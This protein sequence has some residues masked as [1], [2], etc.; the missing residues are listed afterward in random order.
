[1]LPRP[2]APARRLPYTTADMSERLAKRK[3]EQFKADAL[4]KLANYSPLDNKSGLEKIGS[5]I[6]GA[7]KWLQDN[8]PESNPISTPIN[9]GGDAGV[10]MGG[11]GTG[12]SLVTEPARLAVRRAVGDITAIPRVG[13]PSPSYTAD[14][15]REQGV[16]RGVLGAAIDYSQFIPVVAKGAG[17]TGD[18]VNAYKLAMM[19]R[20]ANPFPALRGASNVID[21]VEGSRLPAR[22]VKAPATRLAKAQAARDTP[23][24][25]QQTGYRTEHTKWWDATKH[26]N[27]EVDELGNSFPSIDNYPNHEGIWVTHKF[28]DALKYGDD[29][30][31]VDL[32]NATPIH[33]DG[34]GGYFYIRP[35]TSPA[36]PATPATRLG[37]ALAQRTLDA[38]AAQG[39]VRDAGVLRMPGSYPAGERYVFDYNQSDPAYV[40]DKQSTNAISR[41]YD[42]VGPGEKLIDTKGTE[43]GVPGRSYTSNKMIALQS[44]QGNAT[45]GYDIETRVI[46]GT[47]Q[48]R[49]VLQ[50]IS[51]AKGSV[52]Q[53]KQLLDFLYG[54]YKNAVIDWG[55]ISTELPN[56]LFYEYNNR[57]PVRTVGESVGNPL[58]N[59]N[60]PKTNINVLL[61]TPQRGTIPYTELYDAIG[62]LDNNRIYP[63]SEFKQLIQKFGF[64]GREREVLDAFARREGIV[65]PSRL[66][67]WQKFVNEMQRQIDMGDYFNQ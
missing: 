17:F 47:P 25:P 28:N 33:Y 29:I 46:N 1:M 51:A 8:A 43:T 44:P 19:E 56:E 3:A 66:S 7:V 58:E 31:E 41:S 12:K 11:Q 59:F 48:P 22:V 14:Q 60:A 34:D 5:A 15:I 36:A 63:T 45:L 54:R 6:G 53:V 38:Q 9:M 32:T 65:E 10:S 52:A 18:A 55:N 64:Q 16:A 57:F 21:V 20:Q 27:H 62:V 37:E 13:E 30:R 24:V 35:R 39:G 61:D 2:E 40:I 26:R 49:I 50:P 67:S 23:Y 4:A 42:K